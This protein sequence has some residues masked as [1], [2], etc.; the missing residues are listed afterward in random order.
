MITVKERTKVCRRC[1]EAKAL[2]QYRT[3]RHMADGKHSWCN[4]CVRVGQREWRKNN[5]EKALSKSRRATAKFQGIICADIEQW[6]VEQLERQQ[7]ICAMPDCDRMENMNRGGRFF[8]D[9]DHAT[10]RPRALLCHQCNIALGHYENDKPRHSVFD[11][12]LEE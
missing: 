10:G 2:Y 8:I 11:A 3:H 9:H 7:S 1:G 5:P 6:Y 12:Y 4:S